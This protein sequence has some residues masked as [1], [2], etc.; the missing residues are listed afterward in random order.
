MLRKILLTSKEN[1]F[2]TMLWPLYT[3]PGFSSKYHDLQKVLFTRALTNLCTSIVWHV[4][5]SESEMCKYNNVLYNEQ[6]FLKHGS[7]ETPPCTYVSS[8]EEV[9]WL[10]DNSNKQRCS[11]S[12]LTF[13]TRLEQYLYRE[14]VWKSL[15]SLLCPVHNADKRERAKERG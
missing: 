6:K 13:T 7:C 4:Y 3:F 8:S 11:S 9:Y 14:Q 15:T 10:S 12:T 1:G 2:G 5:S